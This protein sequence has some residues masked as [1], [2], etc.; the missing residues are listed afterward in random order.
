[1]ATCDCGSLT[2]RKNEKPIPDDTPAAQILG[3]IQLVC[4]NDTGVFFFRYDQRLYMR[5]VDC[6]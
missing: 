5:T 4:D 2:P 6:S 1:M 3:K